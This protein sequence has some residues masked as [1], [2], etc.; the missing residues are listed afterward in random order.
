MQSVCGQCSKLKP[1]KLELIK[2]ADTLQHD[3]KVELNGNGEPLSAMQN[4]MNCSTWW[5][6]EVMYCGCNILTC[7]QPYLCWD[8][9]NAKVSIARKKATSCLEMK[10]RMTKQRRVGK[11]G[12]E[13]WT[14]CFRR[15]SKEL[16]KRESQLFICQLGDGLGDTMSMM[17]AHQRYKL[18]GVI[19]MVTKSM[20]LE[21]RPLHSRT[22]IYV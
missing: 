12:K 16:R 18:Q 3:W 20:I 22:V 1:R 8:T 6:K 11:A 21:D 14:G 2:C 9:T 5:H 4:I 19:K 13:G 10:I 17:S 15:T 7:G